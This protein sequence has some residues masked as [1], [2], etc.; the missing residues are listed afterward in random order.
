M[1]PSILVVDDDARLRNLLQRFLT[2]HGFAVETA[3][4]ASQAR[5]QLA[6]KNFDALVL[7]VMMPEE[8]GM[9][10]AKIV[11]K[12]YGLP[13]LMLT[14]CH[15]LKDKIKAFDLGV[16]DYLTK[17][18][19][20]MELLVRLRS[21]LK[22]SP[23]SP[24][25]PSVFQFGEFSFFLQ[26]GDLH[27]GEQ[28]VRLSFTELILLKTLAKNPYAPFSRDALAQCMGHKVDART[29]DVQIGRLR[30]KIQDDPRHP[31]YIQTIRHVGYALCPD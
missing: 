15:E 20:P 22:R 11:P 14:A 9:E 25:A 29:V 7:D 13:I 19:E 1:C 10:F 3:S 2:D 6:C 28:V 21:I 18:F 17:P 16:D 23:A 30:R 26:T 31:R 5:A 8:T 27:K 24:V 12:T 4:N